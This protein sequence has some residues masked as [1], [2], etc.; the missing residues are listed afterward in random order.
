MT[1]LVP[2]PGC[3]RHIHGD[4]PACPFCGSSIA[5]APACQGRCPTPRRG[6]WSRAALFAAGAAVLGAACGHEIEVPLYGAPAPDGGFPTADAGT[7]GSDGGTGS[8]VD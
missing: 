3:N 1:A 2:C 6:R 8:A 7:G 5:Q 4:E